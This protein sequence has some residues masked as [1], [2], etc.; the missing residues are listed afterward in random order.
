MAEDTKSRLGRGLAAL[1]GDVGEESKIAERP[2]GQRRVPI[3][4][5]KPN[6]RNPERKLLKPPN[7]MSW[8]PR[9]E[10]VASFNRSSCARC[11]A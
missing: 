3:E 7:S 8:R 5:L 11:A 9:S 10:S 2:R 1:I 6:P 4:F